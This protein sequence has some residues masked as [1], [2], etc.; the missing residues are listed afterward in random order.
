[1]KQRI[2]LLLIIVSL[3]FY[4]Q[5]KNI[6]IEQ[7][8]TNDRI[9]QGTIDNKHEITI[10]LKLEKYSDD[11]LYIYSVKGWYYYDNIKKK[12]PIFGVFNAMSGLTLFSANDLSFEKKILNFDLPGVVIWDKLDEIEKFDNYSEKLVIANDKVEN[13]WSNKKKK[14]KLTIN[15][16]EDIYIFKDFKFLKIGN[17][18]VDLSGYNLHGKDLKII[19][20]KISLTEVRILLKYEQFGNPNVQG[21][22]GGATDFGYIILVFNNKND[23]A[24]LDEFEIENCRG[25]IF[26]EDLKVDNKK[27]L[28]YKITDSSG[29]KENSRF[30]TIDTESI[31]IIK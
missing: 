16:F 11:H 9:L 27:K 15:N 4:A 25:F 29:N 24:Q 5:K 22:C 6:S 10:Y 13:S 30:L 8:R 3:S 23:L 20:K 21:M 14:L 17:S 7:F 19:S 26:S 2:F 18:R 28:K 12:I 31:T 1:M